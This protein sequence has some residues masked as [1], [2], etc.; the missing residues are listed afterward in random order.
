MSIQRTSFVQDY[1][2]IRF[3]AFMETE[4]GNT[5]HTNTADCPRMLHWIIKKWGTFWTQMFIQ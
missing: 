1:Q 5:F 2:Q 3:K 4:C